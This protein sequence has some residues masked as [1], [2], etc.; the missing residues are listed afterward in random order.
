MS[1]E[2]QKEHSISNNEDGRP[3]H[4]RG[5]ILI[6]IKNNIVIESVLSSVKPVFI[7]EN[8][9]FG[10][11]KP[12]KEQFITHLELYNTIDAN[13]CPGSHLKAL[14]RVRGLWRIYFDNDTDREFMISKEMWVR[15]NSRIMVN[16]NP[17]HLKVRVK[18]V[19]CSAEDGKIERASEYY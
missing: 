14:Q 19:T 16:E 4:S 15:D 9:I 18:N 8:D 6:C 2:S 17:N 3:K 10:S 12:S 7:L 5:N 11:A 1:T 13:I